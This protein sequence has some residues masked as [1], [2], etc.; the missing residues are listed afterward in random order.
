MI[1]LFFVWDSQYHLC[2]CY[3]S[4][5]SQPSSKCAYHVIEIFALQNNV[6][7]D[8]CSNGFDV[9]W[10]NKTDNNNIVETEIHLTEKSRQD[11]SEK[12]SLTTHVFLTT[13]LIQIKGPMI[14]K[15]I[16]EIFPELK[17]VMLDKTCADIT[18]LKQ[19][20]HQEEKCNRE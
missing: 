14:H 5:C 11:T 15:F 2:N 1:A 19:L 6:Y 7:I 12:Q 4:F 20:K 18:L 9:S 10:N 17:A 3:C 13:A 16:K 8:P